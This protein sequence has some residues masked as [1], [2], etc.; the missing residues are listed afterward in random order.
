MG[1]PAVAVL[2][3]AATCIVCLWLSQYQEW[4]YNN[5]LR[6]G[7]IQPVTP[8]WTIPAVIAVGFG[9]AAVALL[10]ALPDLTRR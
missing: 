6:G 8:G 1:R 3:L 5:G 9:G 7:G 2:V 4:V 10:I